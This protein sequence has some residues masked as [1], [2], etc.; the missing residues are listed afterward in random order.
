MMTEISTE[1]LEEVYSSKDVEVVDIREERQYSQTEGKKIPG[2]RLIPFSKLHNSIDEI[3]FKKHVYFICRHGNS[4]LKAVRLAEAFEESDNSEEIASVA[5]GY[6][7]W[8]GPTEDII[9]KKPIC[10]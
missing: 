6:L 5:G 1:K 9:R 7:E 10:Q 3:D 2:S 8:T 4:S